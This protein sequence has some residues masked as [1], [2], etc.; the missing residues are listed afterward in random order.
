MKQLL[1]WVGISFGVIFGLLFLVVFLVYF[2]PV[3]RYI[4]NKAVDYVGTRYGMRLEVGDFRLGFPADLSLGDFYCGMSE[5]D[6]LAVVEFLRLRVG[7]GRLFHRQL[8]VEEMRLEGVKLKMTDSLGM[9]LAVDI[10]GVGLVARQVDLERMR[11]GVEHIE[12]ERVNYR[13]S[14]A[15]LPILQ[16]GIHR[17]DLFNGTVWLDERRMDCDTLVLSGGSCRLVLADTSTTEQ[18]TLQ[19][20]LPSLP[21]TV[22]LGSVRLENS[23]FSMATGETEKVALALSDIGVR[24][25]SVYNRGSVVK[26]R[27]RDLQVAHRDGTAVTGMQAGMGLDSAATWLQGGY[28]RTPNSWL[29]L[30]AYTDTD[31]QHLMEREPLAVQLSGE[32]GMEDIALYYKELPSG[33]RR[34]KMRINAVLSLTDK[35]LQLGQLILDMPGHFKLTGSGSLSSYK[36]PEKINGSLV[37][38][39]EMPDVTFAQAF[40]GDSSSFRIPRNMDM[41]ARLNAGKGMVSGLVRLCNGTGCVTLD[42]TYDMERQQ[43]DAEITA[44]HF[45]VHHFLLMDSLGDVSAVVRCSGQD[46][47]WQDACAEMTVRVQHLRYGGYD[48]DGVNLRLS[49]NQTRLKGMLESMVPDAPLNLVFQGDSVGRDYVLSLGGTLGTIDMRALH[50]MSESFTFGGD[51]DMRVA[52]GEYDQYALDLK[53][54]NL[55]MSDAYR[56]YELGDLVLEGKSRPDRTTMKLESGDLTLRFWADTTLPVF[57]AQCGKAAEV[58]QKQ[59]EHLDVDMVEVQE[60]VPPFALH[61]VGAQ[62]NA[63]ARFLKSRQMGFKQLKADVVAR[64]RSGLRVGVLANAPYWNSVQLDSVQVGAWQTGQSLMYSLTAGSSSEAWKGLFNVIVTGR[65][66]GDRFRTEL[67]QKDAEGNVGFDL[68]VNTIMGDSALTVSLFPVDPIL[69]YNRWEVNPD[70]RVVI[71]QNGRLWADLQMAYQRKRIAFHSLEDEGDRHNR[72]RVDIVGVELDALSR[73]VP[74][75]PQL[76]GVL[77]T[78]MLLYSGTDEMGVDGNVRVADLAYE[79]R[80]IGTVEVGLQH[81]VGNRFTDHTTRVELKIDTVRRVIAEGTFSTA[82]RRDMAIDVDIPSIPLSLANAFLPA[83]LMKLG[84][85][86]RGKMYLRGTLDAPSLNGG[87]VFRGG[88]A[89]VMMLGTVFRLDTTRIAVED[90][91]MSFRKYRF[92]APNNSDMVLNGDVYLTPFDRMNMDMSVDATNFEL[93]NVKKNKTSPIYGKAYADVRSRM[94]GTFADLNVSGNVNLLNRTNINYVLRSTDAE[95]EDKNADFVRFVSFRDTVWNEGGEI[96][97]PVPAGGFGLRMLVEIGDQVKLGVDLSE[98]GNDHVNIQ[99]GGNLVLTLYPESGMALGGKY[100]LTGGT[101]VYNVPIVG[102]KEFS[103]RQGSSVEWTGDLMNPLLDIAAASQLKADVEEGDQSRQVVFESIIRIRNTLSKPDITFDMSAPNDMVIQNQLA[104]FSPEERSRQALNLLIY[105]TY[106]APGAASS[107]ANANLANNALYGF[108]ENELNKYTRRAG[109]TVGF[110]SYNTEENTTRTDVT[111]QFSKQLFNDRVRVK[112]GGRI[113]TD[114]SE[115]QGGSSLQDNLVDDISI[116]YVLTKKRNL[117][118]KVFRHSNY[119]SVLDG[120]VVQTGGGI[121][122]RKNFRKFKDLFKNKNREER[123]AEKLKKEEEGLLENQLKQ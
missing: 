37:V 116:E 46:Y 39:G 96:V 82:D 35:R 50:L 78:D 71:G 32:V 7:I 21:W 38:R 33:I 81:L 28:I 123:R 54:N 14:T 23:V 58:I 9:K 85:E 5:G 57:A 77:N 106:T 118:A 52:L 44:N 62:D 122:W 87:L 117:Y 20:T 73:M 88:W 109:L 91:R 107:T 48:Y 103:I 75:M 98:D 70:N 25:D 30:E 97:P 69:E 63:V 65:M 47:T 93:I 90:G 41:L 110:D 10:G 99:G 119:E 115:G 113:S 8:S 64:K 84:G 66:Q 102:K 120:E 27:L 104:T 26:A 4:K 49:L 89:D 45:P 1:K 29:S 3:Q 24:L 56:R 6:T 94:T 114:G 101:V 40:I 43:Y 19:D 18:E 121:V 17:A 13:M 111:Y 42:A 11:I 34:K 83:D 2:P 79:Q 112:I 67:R 72:L 15:A 95:Y 60:N 59:L 108:V 76:G 51:V 53:L 55:E 74:F 86:L 92:I 31:V 16:A 36:Q 12:L 22:Q 105:N 68:G 61:I 80:R 100:I